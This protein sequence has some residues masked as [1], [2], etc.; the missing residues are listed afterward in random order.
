MGAPV[1]VLVASASDS[2]CHFE[3]YLNQYIHT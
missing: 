1:N 2:L 3:V